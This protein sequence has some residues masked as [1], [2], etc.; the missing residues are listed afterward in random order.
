MDVALKKKIAPRERS[1]IGD[2]A[3]TESRLLFHFIPWLN[4]RVK[5]IT[6]YERNSRNQSEE[7]PYPSAD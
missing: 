6:S 3:R 5:G 1:D 4:Y 2:L 7:T